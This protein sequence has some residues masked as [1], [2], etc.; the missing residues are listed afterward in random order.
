MT[1][2]TINVG[3]G[4]MVVNEGSVSIKEGTTVNMGGNRITNVAPGVNNGDAVTVS[5]LKAV[6]GDIGSLRGDLNRI[7]RDSR[8]GTASAAAM[9]N[10]P[11]AY[12]PGK[13]M[14]AIATAGHR[15]QQGYAVG[16]STLSEGGDWVLKGSVSGNSRGHVTYGAGVGY[17]W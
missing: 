7:D 3:G 5:Q 13:S 11:Q 15:G 1:T 4:T 2:N 14:F 17:Q 9:A 12:L 6:T 10:L 16:L 8:A